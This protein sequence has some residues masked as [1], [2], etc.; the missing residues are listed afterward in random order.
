MCACVYVC[1]SKEFSIL[2]CVISVTSENP[3]LLKKNGDAKLYYIYSHKEFTWL[4]NFFSFFKINEI[5][6][7]S[8]EVT[9]L[10]VSSHGSHQR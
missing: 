7:L 4:V 2:K 9:I 1:D 10:V 3:E 6:H 5:F 8:I